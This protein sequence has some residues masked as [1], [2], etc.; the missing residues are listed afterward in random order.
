M[1]ANQNQVFTYK[2]FDLVILGY[3]NKHSKEK[4]KKVRQKSRII[5]ILWKLTI[6]N[7]KNI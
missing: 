7:M 6:K 3:K 5:T 4:E 1:N 2:G